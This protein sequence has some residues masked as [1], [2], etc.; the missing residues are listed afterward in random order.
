MGQLTDIKC[1]R[2]SILVAGFSV[3]GELRHM[4]E[5]FKDLAFRES[6]KCRLVGG[7]NGLACWC[8][9]FGFLSHFELLFT[10]CERCWFSVGHSWA[11][12]YCLTIQP[13]RPLH[14]SVVMW[15]FTLCEHCHCQEPCHVTYA[16]S[17]SLDTW[18]LAITMPTNYNS[19]DI[20]D[21][22]YTYSCN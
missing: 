13:P 8:C 18:S 12:K 6:H 11:S 2:H 4:V 22:Q 9:Y 20:N 1:R 7:L 10:Q 19:L 15:F 14:W 16:C 3:V 21:L 5:G 17:H